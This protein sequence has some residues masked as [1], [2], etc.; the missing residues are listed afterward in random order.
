MVFVISAT[1]GHSQANTRRSRDQALALL[2]RIA[3]MRDAA[4]PGAP[5]L[6]AGIAMA[7][8]CSI[9]GDVDPNEV[10]HLVDACLQAGAD[11]VA[12]ADTVGYAGPRDVAK[13]A[14][15]ARKLARGCRWPCIS[16]IRAAWQLPMPQRPW[17]KVC[18]SWT[19][20]WAASGAAHSP[21][22]PRAT[23]FSKT[24]CSYARP[25]ASTPA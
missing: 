10:L 17:T 12:L 1:E 11:V 5:V 3:A 19:A 22:A 14:A 7:F 15:A 25:W 18:A 2:S 4:G 23:W 20:R 6:T 24:W 13:L 16:T 9:E 21:P 8:G